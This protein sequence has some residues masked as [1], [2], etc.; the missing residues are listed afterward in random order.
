MEVTFAAF[1][2]AFVCKIRKETG[3]F[4]EE[5]DNSRII[6]KRTKVTVTASRKRLTKTAEDVTASRAK[7]NK[8]TVQLTEEIVKLVGVKQEAVEAADTLP[9]LQTKMITKERGEHNL[10]HIN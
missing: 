4:L 5:M 2:Q 10:E 7:N 9:S 3:P 8:N 6:V 1:H